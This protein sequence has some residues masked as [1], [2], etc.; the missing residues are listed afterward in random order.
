MNHL[1]NTATTEPN[2]Y[3][4]FQFKGASY[5][6]LSTTEGNKRYNDLEVGVNQS[7][8]KI[9]VHANQAGNTAHLALEA[10]S[11]DEADLYVNTDC[12]YGTIYFNVNDNQYMILTDWNDEVHIH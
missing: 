11:R 12:S 6:R 9:K 5:M 1:F 2:P 7:Q 3:M 8:S 4:Y 10:K